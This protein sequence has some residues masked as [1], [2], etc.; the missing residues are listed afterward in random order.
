MRRSALL[1]LILSTCRSSDAQVLIPAGV[2]TIDITPSYPTRLHGYY[3]RKS[4]ATGVS[5]AIS[6]KALGIGSDQA[7]ASILITID[8]RGVPDAL[9]A[10]L[11][12][13]LRARVGLPREALVVAAS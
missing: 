3:A 2:A 4:E 9:V 13:R 10:R 7:G 12:E 6:A 1:L 11:A 5:Q 8:S